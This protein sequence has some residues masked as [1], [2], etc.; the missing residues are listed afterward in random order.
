MDLA[1]HRQ[2]IADRSKEK[3]MDCKV[4]VICTLGSST[5]IHEACCSPTSPTPG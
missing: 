3:L 2:V 4:Y 5:Y 1:S